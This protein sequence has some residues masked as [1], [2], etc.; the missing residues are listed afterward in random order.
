[1]SKYPFKSVRNLTAVVAALASI[2]LMSTETVQAEEA[3]DINEAGTLLEQAESQVVSPETIQAD[4]EKESTV[5]IAHT[6][7]VHGRMQEDGKTIGTAKASVFFD[8]I[9]ADIVVD[10]G[11]AFQGL[12]LSNHDSGETMNKAMTEAGYQ[13]IAVGNHEFDFGQDIALKYG[14]KAVKDADPNQM[15]A[16]SSN[17]VNTETGELLFQPSKTIKTENGYHVAIIGASTPETKTKTHPKNVANVE[18]TDP[19]PAVMAEIDRLI[20]DQEIKED[21][22]IVLSHLGVDP[23]TPEKWRGSTLAKQLDAET[24]YDQYQI[25]VIDGHSHTVAPAQSFGNVLYQQTG[26]ALNNIGVI[27]FD[28]SQPG[29]A[30]GRLYDKAAVD[31]IVGNEVD[32]EVAKIIEQAAATYKE[33][34]SRVII[35]SNPVWLNGVREYVRSQ[36]SNLGNLITDAMVSYGR[37]GGF[38]NPTSFA[39]INGGGIREP[40][41]KDE[42]ITEGD[43]IAVLP[44]GNI[45][46]Q[47]TVTGEQIYDMFEHAYRAPIAEEAYTSSNGQHT[48]PAIDEE[49][50]LPNLTANGGFLQISSDVKVYFNPTAEEG[51][52]VHAVYLQNPET[53]EFELVAKDDSKE[54][55]M[56]TND[57]LAQGGDGYDM[58]S[59]AREEGPSL[60][61]VVMDM[62]EKGGK[63]YLLQYENPLPTERIFAM[64][65]EDYNKLVDKED[66]DD[67]AEN[68]GK[69]DSAKDTDKDDDDLFSVKLPQVITDALNKDQIASAY[70]EDLGAA[71]VFGEDIEKVKSLDI[72]KYDGTEVEDKIEKLLF[73]DGDIDL[74]QIKLTD[75]DG[76]EVTTKNG[77]VV[78]LFVTPGKKVK[79]IVHLGNRLEISESLDF[80]A[81]DKTVEFYTPNLSYFA[82]V[83]EYGKEAVGVADAQSYIKELKDLGF[84]LDEKAVLGRIQE[85]QAGQ[86]AQIEK[87]ANKNE[88]AAVKEEK[89]EQADASESASEESLPQTGATALSALAASAILSGLGCALVGS[90]RKE[91][92]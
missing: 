55:Y 54:Y 2:G 4:Q 41:A 76:K 20:E 25:I 59:G 5:T 48:V 47:I 79:D 50:G 51:K 43:V 36:E 38:N 17:A 40:I 1:M 13:A 3:T 32:E 45:I 15:P 82:V 23:A 90:A 26:T 16:L 80:E 11:D 69:D 52:R 9:D 67:S 74:Y 88:T 21:A 14:S 53:K 65:A 34:T 77:T 6:N 70:V 75:K 56:A 35:E 49:S 78:R 72:T 62:M 73:K 92:N 27:T 83:Y 58:L 46:S 87:V 39:M 42:A 8:K 30:H 68:A 24:K 33:E 63:D 19:I 86:N 61:Q 57:F 91:D 64:T 44:F 31:A 18:F 84:D 60:D 22:F 10:A 7:D 28:P 71:F 89:A 12:P 29:Q 66:Q 37:D 81:D 85:A